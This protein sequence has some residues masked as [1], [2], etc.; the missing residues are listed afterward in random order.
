MSKQIQAAGRTITVERPSVGK[1]NQ[2][3]HAV[4]QLMHEWNGIADEDRP[5]VDAEAD[6]RAVII[7]E[8]EARKVEDETPNRV[9][10]WDGHDFE[11][12]PFRLP[13]PPSM[14]ERIIRAFPRLMAIAEPKV[15]RLLALLMMSNG[16]VKHAR[17]QGDDALDTAIEVQE[18]VV[19]DDLGLDEALELVMAALD[20]AK[21]LAVPLGR[22][23]LRIGSSS[24]PEPS[25]SS[26]PPTGGRAKRS[27]NSRGRSTER[28]PV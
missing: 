9:W 14:E 21:E 16:D 20:V 1:G 10:Q 27:S 8:A 6:R 23:G 26:P 11:T 15:V 17:S 3:I 2:I 18:R 5:W 22:L 19:L 12:G 28:T 4:G 25:T 13:Q 7:T 24:T